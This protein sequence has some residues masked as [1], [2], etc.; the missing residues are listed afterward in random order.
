MQCDDPDELVEID[1]SVSSALALI[2]RVTGTDVAADWFQA[3][4]SRVEPA[5]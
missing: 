5:P 3:R 1:E 2:G 4:H